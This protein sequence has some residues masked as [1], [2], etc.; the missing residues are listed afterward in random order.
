[1][2][3]VFNEQTQQFHL[4]NKNISYVMQILKDTYLI[5][6]YFGERIQTFNQVS[7][8]PKI[9]RS[10][11]SPNP[12]GWEDRTFSLDTA[13]QE[14]PGFDTGDYR[15]SMFEM[16]YPDGTKATTFTY[17]SYRIFNGKSML[18][19]LPATYVVEQEEAETLEITL[20]DNYRQVEVVLSY[21]I[22][23]DRNVIAKS[24]QYRNIGKE[25]L[26][27]NKALSSCLDFDHSQFEL[28]QLPGAWAR[29]KQIERQKL[30][31]GILKLDSKR[32][33]SGVAQQPFIALVSPETTENFGEVW[34]THFVYSGNFTLTTEVDNFNQTRVLSGINPHN[35]NWLL[36]EGATF[37]TPE[38]IHVYSN[39][40]LNGMSHTFHSLYRERLARGRHQFLERPVLINNWETTYFDFNEEQLV[41]LAKNAKQLGV[42]LFVLDDGWFGNRNNDQTSLGDWFENKQK[43]PDGLAGLA[44]K[45]KKEGLKFGLWFE[46]EMISKESELFKLHPDWHI[47]VKDYPTTLGRNQLI[48]DF[49]RPEIVEAVYQQMI[50]ILDNVTIDYIK[51]DM[52]RNMTEIG[53]TTARPSRQMETAHRYILGLYDLLERLTNRYPDI[54]FENCSGGGGRFDPGMVH[55]MPQS[56]ASD[57]TD[58]IERLKIQYGTSLI[59]PPIMIC[60]QISEVPNHQ[61]GRIT[62]IE[63]RIDVASSG[64]LGVMLNL[65]TEAKEELEVVKQGIEWYK[66]HRSLLQF[67]RFSRLVNPFDQNYG[68]WQFTDCKKES[69]VLFFY[70]ILASASK[71]FVRLKLVDLEPEYIYQIGEQQLSGDELMKYG[72]YV[73]QHFN[74]DFKSLKLEYKRIK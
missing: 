64:N 46:P 9:D 48:L 20:R 23:Q 25:T 35:F 67:G 47:H 19:G 1:M 40:G 56:W 39:Q 8:Y 61:V 69:G 16:T 18:D 15:E 27:L 13:L 66:T 14:I 2:S 74:G 32:G 71:P 24:A 43:L 60:S 45:I 42:E 33:A 37:Q 70:Q 38:V 6:L 62:D 21:T 73:G 4:Q 26:T 57:N 12:E 49:S 65:K 29:E 52:N 10:S 51:W 11:F 72:L 44:N 68:A 54:L 17:H 7:P 31:K 5:Q 58:A 30:T 55:Y 3:I 50:R 34:G 22:Y 59:F 41:E 53:S 63:T 28:I 36:E